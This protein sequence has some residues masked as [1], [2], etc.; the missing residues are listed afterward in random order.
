MTT[1]STT[2]WLRKGT[3]PKARGRPPGCDASGSHAHLTLIQNNV[4]NNAEFALN[5]EVNSGAITVAE[6]AAHAAQNEVHM[7]NHAA[8]HAVASVRAEARV[9]KQ[10]PE[11]SA[12]R[13]HAQSAESLMYAETLANRVYEQQ[14]EQAAM[15]ACAN[16]VL[17]SQAR[18]IHEANARERGVQQFVRQI[19]LLQSNAFL[20]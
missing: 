20:L 13:A 12:Q 16:T 7:M 11:F 3:I 2:H 5:T 10:E 14:R 6:F 17:E 4:Q 8:Q 18:Q 15:A 9:T 19:R 1:P